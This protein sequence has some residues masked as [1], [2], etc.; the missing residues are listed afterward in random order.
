MIHRVDRVNP[1]VD[2]RVIKPNEARMATNLRFGASTD[3]TN[4]SGGTLILGNDQLTA[5]IPPTGTNKVVG[6][7]ADLESRNVFFAMYNNNGNH[8]IYR[9]NGTTNAVEA[10]A[11]GFWLAFQDDD[12]YNVSITGVDGKLYWTDNVNDPRV[13]NVEKGIRTQA[14]GTVDVYPLNPEDWFYTQI[15]RPPGMALQVNPKLESVPEAVSMSKQNKALTNTGFQY[16]YYYVYDN[17]EESRLAP[18]S[19]NTFGNYNIVVTI[20]QDE[21]NAY[22]TNTSLIKA[23]VIVIRNGNDGV[24]REIKYS[25]NDGITRVFTFPNILAAQRNTVPSD[26]TDARFD[27]VPLQSATNEIAQNKINHANYNLD[28]APIDTI[29]FNAEIKY[30]STTDLRNTTDPAYK[31]KSFMPWG[32]YSIGVEFVDKFGRT[33]PVSNV[34]EVVAPWWR[35]EVLT[36]NTLRGGSSIGLNDV[37]SFNDVI[38]NVIYNQKANTVA[39]FSITGS[40]PDWVDRVNIVRSKCK[41]IIQMKQSLGNVFMWYKNQSD[42]NEFFTWVNY[43]INPYIRNKPQ[44]QWPMYE[45]YDGGAPATKYT[46]YGYVIEFNS[47][48]PITATDNQYIY[49]PTG[50]FLNNSIEPNSDPNNFINPNVSRFK[51]H[52]ILGNKIYILASDNVSRHPNVG[53]YSSSANNIIDPYTLPVA[54]FNTQVGN[55]EMM[56][57]IENYI[58]LVYNFVITQEV[59]AD[60]QTLYTT[61][62]SYS[63]AEYNNAINNNTG[64]ALTGYLYGDAYTCL[65][66][67]TTRS[68]ANT[69]KIFN[70]GEDGGQP[71]IV[72]V[73]QKVNAHG[74]YGFFIS[75]NPVDIWREQWNQD[76]G[77]L[78]TTDYK[79]SE[80]RILPSNICFSGNIIQGT[81]VNGLNKFNSLD[82]RQAPAENGPITA[83]VTT[84]ATQREPGVLLAI[85]TYGISSFYY[86]AIQLTN[87]DGSNNVSTT[88]SYLASQR[89]LVGQFGTSRPMSVTKTPLGTVYWWSDVVNDLIRYSNAGLERLGSTFSFSNYLRKKFNDNPFIIT[90]Y[91]QVTDEISLM[92]RGQNTAVFSERYKTFQG[93]RQYWGIGPFGP[94]YP[95]RGIGLPTKQ[96]WFLGG[97]IYLSNVSQ[98]QVAVPPNFLFGEFKDP[99]VLLVTNESPS[100]VKRWNQV[101]VYGNRPAE[102]N[103]VAPID[104][105]GELRSLIQPNYF[106]QRKGDWEAAIRRASNTPGGIMAGKLM[107]SRII[108]SNFAFSAEGFEKLNFIEV[109]S[110]VSI[111]Q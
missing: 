31:F 98:S 63:A 62:V 74:W 61:Q 96:Y 53:D 81:Q 109:K 11:K 30:T 7:Y 19:I 21:F 25:V 84:N 103:L 75:M 68:F 76:I 2:D 48:E 58:P 56:S 59:E 79:K 34:S 104:D 22:A 38:P 5:F 67:K 50:F 102:V 3:D 93:E 4:L 29:R 55:F 28:Y 13:I 16:S 41:N 65:A 106:I 35:S 111:V 88:D 90:W 45:I 39:E 24:W 8:G 110:N 60:E 85:G 57:T 69:I 105:G 100:T 108:Y 73:D 52:N 20:P 87:I 18:Y 42:G 51:V 40:I 89:P 32:R 86:D 92:G 9:I 47:F 77:Q 10:V 101:K 97:N 83:L 36:G 72:N 6:V 43:G 94:V 15:K 64:N 46:F 54:C 27:T 12:A 23:I 66:L 80:N 99:S 91:D 70:P 107:E 26:I 49:L 37:N 71:V 17:F 78:N 33:Q 44:N 14:G 1:D 82:F 95:E